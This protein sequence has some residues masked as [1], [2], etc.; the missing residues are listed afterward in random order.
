[1]RCSLALSLVGLAVAAPAACPSNSN[2]S[3]SKGIKLRVKLQDASKDLPTFPVSGQYV[4][5]IHDGA[6]TN[7]VG[8]SPAGRIFYVNGTT[9]GDG[10]FWSTISDG[11]TPPA[12]Y[13]LSLHTSPDNKDVQVVRLDVGEG[14]KDIY[15]P[16]AG[17]SSTPQLIP[18]GWL[19]CEEPLAYYG[20]KTFSVLRRNAFENNPPKECVGVSLLPECAVL[21]DLPKGSLASHEFAQNVG[22][23]KDAR[24]A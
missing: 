13:G 17:A 19:A 23:Y 12:P 10:L 18:S 14:D 7:L 20:N 15:V 21:N 11:G 1:M 5:S 16:A 24:A 4:T 6:G 22:C 3:S 9:P 8:F 2:L